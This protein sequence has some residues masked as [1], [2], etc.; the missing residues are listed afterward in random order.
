MLGCKQRVR[1]L[2]FSGCGTLLSV[3]GKDQQGKQQITLWDTSTIV[4]TM[5]VALITQTHTDVIS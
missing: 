1:C 2:S 4:Q 3:V 5:Q